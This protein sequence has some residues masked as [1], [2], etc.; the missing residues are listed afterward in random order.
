MKKFVMSHLEV[1]EIDFAPVREVDEGDDS[2][3]H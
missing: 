2:R 3:R 1:R